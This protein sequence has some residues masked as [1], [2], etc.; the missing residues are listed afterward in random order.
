MIITNVCCLVLSACGEYFS[1][2][3]LVVGGVMSGAL[4]LG[5]VMTVNPWLLCLSLNL[6]DWV[7]AMTRDI[8]LWSW[9]RAIYSHSASLHPGV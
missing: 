1:F 3:C 6:V 5:G 8:V 7:C 2:L 4:Y 9:P